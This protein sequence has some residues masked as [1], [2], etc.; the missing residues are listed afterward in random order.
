MSREKLIDIA[1]RFTAW[2]SSPDVNP[3]SA[4]AIVSPNVVVHNPLPGLSPD[5]AGLLTQHKHMIAAS[6]DRQVDVK[7]VSVDETNCM[8]TQF[9]ETTGTQ[10]GYDT[11]DI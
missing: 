9:F 4:S 6:S 8:V 10:T 3:S 2:I 1:N 11:L 5:F 7:V